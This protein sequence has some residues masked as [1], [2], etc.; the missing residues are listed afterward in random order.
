MLDV[1]DTLST[2]YYGAQYKYK[3][4]NTFGY[5]FAGGRRESD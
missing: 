2:T 5:N 3:F 4:N 1:R